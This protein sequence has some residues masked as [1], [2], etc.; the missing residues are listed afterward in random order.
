MANRET[1]IASKSADD[2]SVEVQSLFSFSS[3]ISKNTNTKSS[4]ENSVLLT[5][6]FLCQNEKPLIYRL[7]LSIINLHISY[8]FLLTLFNFISVN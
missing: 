3:S 2:R 5:V 7:H 1:P 6:K 4:F 8:D